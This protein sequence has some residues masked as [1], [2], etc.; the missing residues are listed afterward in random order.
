LTADAKTADATGNL[1][2]VIAWTEEVQ[3]LDETNARS[4]RRDLGESHK[5]KYVKKPFAAMWLNKGTEADVA[6]AQAY[7]RAEGK[8]VF[9]YTGGGDPLGRA[10]ADVLRSGAGDAADDNE[11]NIAPGYQ[12]KTADAQA[13]EDAK[14]VA[15]EFKSSGKA[16]AVAKAKE[17]A[18]GQPAWAVGALFDKALAILIPGDG[19]EA[20]LARN[21]AIRS[22]R[23]VVADSAERREP[24]TIDSIGEEKGL[25]AG[26]PVNTEW[27]RLDKLTPEALAAEAKSEGIKGEGKTDLIMALLRKN[28]STAQFDAWSLFY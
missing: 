17:L 14:V 21:E 12:D 10:K 2:I 18:T 28:F 15:Q 19:R 3:E 11:D 16:A 7:A 26:K 23:F 9:T 4:V 1:Q 24:P 27:L 22:G 20:R 5:F 25:A 13:D 6:K 8:K